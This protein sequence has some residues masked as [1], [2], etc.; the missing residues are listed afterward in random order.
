MILVGKKEFDILNKLDHKSIVKS[1]AFFP[2]VEA[3]R[4]YLVLE[5]VTGTTLDELGSK[6]K[7]STENIQQI[8]Y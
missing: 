1:V 7:L 3:N 4:C 8:I 5:K 6:S 2:D